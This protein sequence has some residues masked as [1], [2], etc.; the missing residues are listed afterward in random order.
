MSDEEYYDLQSFFGFLLH[1]EDELA[2]EEE[3]V[4]GLA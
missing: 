3:V 2:K 1:R 4:L